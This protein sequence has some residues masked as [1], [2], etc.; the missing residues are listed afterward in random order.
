MTSSHPA[1][2]WRRRP[3]ERRPEILEAAFQV[4]GEMGFQGATLAHIARKAGVSAGTLGFYFGSKQELFDATILE[5]ATAVLRGEEQLL[6]EHRGTYTELLEAFLRRVWERM[7]EPGVQE[8][9]LMMEAESDARQ[10]PGWTAVKQVG[11]QFQ[12]LYTGIIEA[13]VR[14]G[15]FRPVD[16][17]LVGRVIGSIPWGLGMGVRHASRCGQ[18]LD[19]DAL[20]AAAL[21]LVM[22]ALRPVAAAGR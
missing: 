1:P 20:W 13:G 22:H 17:E 12:R 16:A 14:A 11:E 15:E 5:K 6:L 18:A 2:R 8:F 21:D 10:G 7:S 9:F 3:D 19:R 4:F